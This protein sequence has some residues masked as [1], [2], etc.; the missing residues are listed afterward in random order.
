MA[1]N[2]RGRKTGRS[3][4]KVSNDRKEKP[5]SKEASEDERGS[6]YKPRTNDPAWYATD[7][8]LLRDAASIPF[9]WA[10]GTPVNYQGIWN[11]Q[12]QNVDLNSM[13]YTIPGICAIKLVPSIGYSDSPNSPINVA[14]TSMY[15]F[16]RHANSGHSN[17]ESSDLML[18]VLS[19]TQVYSYINWLQRLYG[20]ATLYANRNR[21]LPRGIF[22]AEGISFDDVASNLANFRYGINLMI[23]KA[24]SLAVPAAFTIFQRHA[25]IYRDIYTEG[26]SIKD[27]L[28]L[29][30]PAGF[31]RYNDGEAGTAGSISLAVT[32]GLSTVDDLLKFGNSLLDPIIQSEDMNIMSGDIL[33]AYGDGNIIKVATL[34][35]YYPLLPV[36]DIGVLEQMHNS[37]CINAL[38]CMDALT[39]GITQVSKVGET[40]LQ[41]LQVLD[42]TNVEYRTQY[43]LR[44]IDYLGMNRMLTTSTA[45][46]SPELVIESTRL[47]LSWG[48]MV[49]NVEHKYKLVSGTEIPVGITYVTGTQGG[50]YSKYNCGSVY[51]PYFGA[52]EAE[53]A[54]GDNYSSSAKILG[55]L[56][57]FRFAPLTAIFNW[58]GSTMITNPTYEFSGFIG[59]VGNYAVI[60]TQDLYKLHETAIMN[61]LHVPSI[62]RLK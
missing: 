60:N 27:Q 59:D 29:Y 2:K 14:A 5:W 23:N 36:F 18:Y 12:H 43:M 53:T 6:S 51:I 33:K 28:Y 32:S 21:Y 58:N 34:P 31:W 49:P 4:G 11:S 30:T 38:N 52:D 56:T 35:E 15:S 61:E 37:V 8:S 7:P 44:S 26:S 42:L 1:N 41:C 25:M 3:N 62:A 46:S 13:V 19:M 20:E 39:T 57:A 54:S 24:A 40:Y 55:M 48:G 16:V 45:E 50:S 17:Y 10:I 9:S 47:M 22:A